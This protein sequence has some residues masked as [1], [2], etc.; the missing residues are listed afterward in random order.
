M[1]LGEWLRGTP[2]GQQLA[3]LS[4]TAFKQLINPALQTAYTRGRGDVRRRDRRHR[5]VRADDRADA[6]LEPYGDIP[7]PVARVCEL[8]SY[9]AE[10]DIHPNPEGYRLI[11]DLVVDAYLSSMAGGAGG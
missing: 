1:I 5:R 4:V 7:V 9:C 3:E 10:R 8:T 11:A 6:S 2:E